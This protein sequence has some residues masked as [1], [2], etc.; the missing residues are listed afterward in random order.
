MSVYSYDKPKTLPAV[1]RRAEDSTG[2]PLSAH[3]T[4][5]DS[6]PPSPSP[7]LLSA[8]S[9][10]SWG[11]GGLSPAR[12]SWDSPVWG[13]LWP[14]L[15]GESLAD[16]QAPRLRSLRGH[17]GSFEVKTAASGLPAA[18]CACSSSFHGPGQAHWGWGVKGPA[19]S[20]A[21]SETHI[22]CFPNRRLSGARVQVRRHQGALPAQSRPEP[23]T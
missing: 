15:P 22:S 2:L 10:G 20:P 13:S 5:L 21:L 6:S 9:H 19:A 18:G 12:L 14:V 1:S 4:L 7:P 3:R 23:G 8:G 11:L 17:R 16:R